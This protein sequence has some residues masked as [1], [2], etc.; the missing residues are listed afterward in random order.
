MIEAFEAAGGVAK[1]AMVPRDSSIFRRE[2][3]R[4]KN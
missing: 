1:L 2:Y 4:T 3:A